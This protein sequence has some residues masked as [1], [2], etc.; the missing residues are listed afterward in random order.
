MNKET[1]KKWVKETFELLPGLI[2]LLVMLTATAIKFET[3]PVW[4]VVGFV[5]FIIILIS[6]ANQ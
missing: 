4:A 1:I 6:A 5:I 2:I 3:D